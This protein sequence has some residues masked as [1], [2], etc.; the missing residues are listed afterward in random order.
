[1]TI[2][3]KAGR[4]GGV[5]RLAGRRQ[6][7][8]DC[9]RWG[10]QGR[11]RPHARARVISPGGATSCSSPRPA[12][13]RLD[14]HAPLRDGD[15]L[16]PAAISRRRRTPPELAAIEDSLPSRSSCPR[17]RSL[18]RP[19]GRAPGGL[20]GSPDHGR[21]GDHQHRRAEDPGTGRGRR[22]A[23]VTGGSRRDREAIVRE[24]AR[25]GFTVHFTWPRAGRIAARRLV[26]DLSDSARVTAHRLDVRERAGLREAFRR[27]RRRGGAL[28]VLVN[29]AGALRD[30]LF[31]L[32]RRGRMAGRR[33]T[34]NLS[35]PRTVA[36]RRSA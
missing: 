6:T 24:L 23:I 20:P 21:S 14:G 15:A 35:G 16:R 26:A 19:R 10:R 2:F 13:G 12:P 28:D 34:I 3:I 22:V 27:D 33:S 31:A 5:A 18:L 32:P 25:A 11:H 29:N 36:G 1:M 4:D 7:L 8:S 30:G 9:T 17:P